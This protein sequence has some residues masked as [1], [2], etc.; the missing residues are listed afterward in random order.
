MLHTTAIEILGVLIATVKQNHYGL[1]SENVTWSPFATPSASPLILL[2]AVGK[3]GH[4]WQPHNYE[5]LQW[6]EVILLTQHCCK[7][8]WL[9]N[10]WL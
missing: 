9:L 7:F 8:E 5:T 6:P 1:L 3:K 4:K 10:E 2:V